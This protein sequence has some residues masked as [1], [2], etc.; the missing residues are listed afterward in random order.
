MLHLVVLHDFIVTFIAFPL[1]KILMFI[2]I[3]LN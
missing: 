3:K 2:T 1:V